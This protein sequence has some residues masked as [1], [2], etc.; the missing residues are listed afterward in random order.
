MVAHGEI[1][2]ADNIRQKTLLV[3]LPLGQ[4]D[5]STGCLAQP[6]V[7]H[8]AGCNYVKIRFEASDGSRS[9]KAVYGTEV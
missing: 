3:A 2:G 9:I 7:I 6:R 5:S 4:A 8:I 1:N